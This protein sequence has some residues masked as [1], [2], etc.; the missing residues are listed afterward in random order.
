MNWLI[1]WAGISASQGGNLCSLTPSSSCLLRLPLP[2]KVDGRTFPVNFPFAMILFSVIKQFSVITINNCSCHPVQN[3]PPRLCLRYSGRQGIL[4]AYFCSFLSPNPYVDSGFSGSLVRRGVS[5]Q[6]L[7]H[8]NL[9]DSITSPPGGGPCYRV[10]PLGV[11][12]TIHGDITSSDVSPHQA[13]Q[14]GCT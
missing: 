2:E 11:T 3:V 7:V 1:N 14:A 10:P 4:S 12:D 13:C 6:K 5:G 9:A 8:Q